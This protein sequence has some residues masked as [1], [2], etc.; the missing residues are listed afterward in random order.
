MGELLIICNI[1]VKIF[2]PFI[3]A[4]GDCRLGLEMINCM[5]SWQ[6]LTY[7]G[8]LVSSCLSKIQGGVASAASATP[9]EVNCLEQNR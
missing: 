7:S 2:D 3:L 1:L 9:N 4:C 5:K 8:L 6:T